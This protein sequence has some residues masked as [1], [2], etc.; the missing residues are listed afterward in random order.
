MTS[1]TSD[2]V[3]QAS[4]GDA[5]AVEE[6]LTRYLPD[7]VSYVGRHAAE[8][9]TRRESSDDLAL[10]VCR[11]ALE[12]LRS[13]RFH[14]QG[15]G[16]FR[17]WLYRAAVMKL[18]TRHRHWRAERRDPAREVERRAPASQTGG[19]RLDV[20]EPFHER[21]PSLDAIQSEELARFQQA[22][23]QLSPRHQAVIELHHVEGL[24]HAEIGARLEISEANSRVL[25]SRALSRLATRAAPDA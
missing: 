22:F 14:Y 1:P 8:L 10:S 23:A 2:L 5:R 12:C 19:A 21:T 13:G 16:P 3:T 18:M 25:L 24:T 20:H 9:V 7:L 11:E 4:Q 17:Q 6:L 15:E